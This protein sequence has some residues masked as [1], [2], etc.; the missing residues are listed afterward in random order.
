M[1]E[2]L[3]GVLPRL[4]PKNIQCW[5]VVFEGKQDLEK[6]LERKLRGWKRPNS[7]FLV[8]RDQDSAD[9]I[10]VKK[11]LLKLCENAGK[12]ETLVRIACHELESFYFGDLYA[13][14]TGL[15]LRSIATQQQKAKYRVPD[16]IVN[17]SYE[18]EKLTH[19]TY[20]K[21]AGS[22]SIGPLLSLEDNSSHSFRILLSGIYSLFE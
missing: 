16:D 22:R 8:I 15:N 6:Q 13:V 17:P 9:C 5:Y 21:I 2:M 18:L 20:Q 19:G 7:A 3:K 10:K 4:L 1:R 11:R 14:E 12:P